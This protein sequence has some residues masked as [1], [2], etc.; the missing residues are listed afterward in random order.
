MNYMFL[1]VT[2]STANY[3]A[4]LIGWEG[5]EVQNGVFFHGGDSKYSD[6]GAE[7]AR[8][9]LISE[10]GWTIDDGGEV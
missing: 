6:G 9:R 8:S 10:H 5:Q 3:D 2:L 4:L 7:D 1:G